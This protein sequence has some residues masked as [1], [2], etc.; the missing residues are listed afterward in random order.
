MKSILA[1]CLL[2]LSLAACSLSAQTAI[3]SSTYSPDSAAEVVNSPSRWAKYSLPNSTVL[4]TRIW[5]PFNAYGSRVDTASWR[6]PM[7][8]WTRLFDA[9]KRH[10]NVSYDVIGE[11]GAGNP[12]RVKDKQYLFIK[13]Y[14]H[15]G[16][17]PVGLQAKEGS[18]MNLQS[19]WY[20]GARSSNWASNQFN[21]M[22]EIRM[23]KRGSDGKI[24]A[25]TAHIIQIEVLQS[26]YGDP[27][28]Y[29]G[30]SR[31]SPRPVSLSGY[32]WYAGNDFSDLYNDVYK[33]TLVNAGISSDSSR[34]VSLDLFQF[35]NYV[36]ANRTRYGYSRASG[37]A[38]I[39][40]VNAGVEVGK[41]INSTVWTGSYWGSSWPK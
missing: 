5:N 18:T 31:N 3:W 8:M 23:A 20:L 26:N 6:M 27:S 28:K 35:I 39:Y 33:F 7:Q 19:E 12:Y 17:K 37:D 2:G 38:Y 30:W 22:W 25:S 29:N 40:E 11:M 15:I 36:L 24:I 14:P 21:A 9:T 41:G 16:Y 1:K 4:D 34:T 13:A 32:N 10:W